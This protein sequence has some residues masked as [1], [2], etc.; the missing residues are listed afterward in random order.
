MPISWFTFAHSPTYSR[1]NLGGLLSDVWP[2]CSCNDMDY[3]LT[4]LIAARYSVPVAVLR[5]NWGAR[6]FGGIWGGGPLPGAGDPPAPSLD[7]HVRPFWALLPLVSDISAWTLPGFSMIT[8]SIGLAR[9]S[10]IASF[11]MAYQWLV[12]DLCLRVFT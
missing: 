7:F 9:S 8:M 2:T 4:G 1:F 6:T 3:C 11:S 10:W 12:L 5:S